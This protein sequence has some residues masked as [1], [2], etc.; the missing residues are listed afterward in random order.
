MIV[1]KLKIINKTGL[2]ARP[3]TLFVEKAKNFISKIT[4]EKNGRIVDAKSLISVLS[5]GIEQGQEIIL[6]IEGPDENEA[7]KELKTLIESGLGEE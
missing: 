5:L 6:K 2:H 4:I 3:A 7:F 1:E